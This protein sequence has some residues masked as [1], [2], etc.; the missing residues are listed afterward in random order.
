MADDLTEADSDAMAAGWKT[1]FGGE[2]RSDQD[3]EALMKEWAA[4]ADDDDG[5]W[6]AAVRRSATERYRRAISRARTCA[7]HGWRVYRI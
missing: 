7:R 1:P 4:M 3:E 2:P 6:T 5:I